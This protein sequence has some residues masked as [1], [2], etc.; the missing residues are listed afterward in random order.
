MT[1]SVCDK[2]WSTWVTTSLMCYGWV[3]PAVAAGADDA[4]AAFGITGWDHHGVEV[5]GRCWNVEVQ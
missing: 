5:L 4:G 2:R 1:P 3:T